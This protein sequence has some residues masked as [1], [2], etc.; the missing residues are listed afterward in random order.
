MI[1]EIDW[2]TKTAKYSKWLNKSWK[3][4]LRTAKAKLKQYKDTISDKRRMLEHEYKQ[5][6]KLNEKNP[7]KVPLTLS[8]SAAEINELKNIR[9]EWRKKIEVD[10]K[11]WQNWK[12]SNIAPRPNQ[13]LEQIK[14]WNRVDSHHIEYDSKLNTVLRDAAF[15]RIMDNKKDR[16]R[17]FLQG[18]ANN[19]L[20]DA[21][22]VF[23]QSNMGELSRIFDSYGMRDQ[24]HRCIQTR[25]WRYNASYQNYWNMDAETAYKTWWVVGL[26]NN[27]LIKTLPNA[28]PEHVS[29]FTNIAVTVGWIYAIY[30]IW[31]WFFGKNKEGNRNLLWKT[32][33]LASLYFVPQLLLWK[34]WYS[35]LW[36]ILSWK[37]DFSE[38][39]YRVSNSLWFLNGSSPE[40]YNQMAPGLLWMHIFPTGYTVAHVRA[41]QQTFSDQNVR[42]QRY[43]VTYARLNRDNTALANEF[44]NT[45]NANEY[46]EDEWKAFL[47]KL[48]IKDDARWDTVIFN[49]AAKTADKKTSFE[50][51][52]KSQWKE[53]KSEFKK[54]IDNYLKEDWEFNPANL[55]PD[56][57]KDNNEATYTMRE[58]DFTK[59]EKLDSKVDNLPI[60]NQKKSELK[61]AL[62]SF[63]DE[64][65]IANKP[66]PDDFDLKM[67]NGLLILKTNWWHESKIKLDTKEIEWF[68]PWIKF[69]DLAD[70]LNTADLANKILETQKWKIAKDKP[71]FQYKPERKWICFN[72]AT[73]LRQDLINRNNTWMD[74]RVLST[75]RWW[76]TSKIDTLYER[77]REFAKYL[78][79]RREEENK[80]EIDA[81][82]YPIVN[83]LSKTWITFTN[84][85]EVKE[86]ENWLQQVK[87]KKEASIW[88]IDWDSFKTSRKWFDKKLVFVNVNWEEDVFDGDIPEKFPTIILNKDKFLNFM[89]DKNNWMWWSKLKK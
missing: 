70:L 10:I 72:D 47:T 27:T 26:L 12:S 37:A 2:C 16:A 4:T 21:Q 28:K 45:F 66:D 38:L 83:A 79:D 53:K 32:A 56:W 62:E 41:L 40:V 17:E 76:A 65:T 75:G 23:Y 46:K 18:I 82:L 36:E 22:I 49:E 5:K 3:E 51:W 73:G 43:S 44:K 67:E 89:N 39:K 33:W 57:F 54:E 64:R 55:N 63:Y 8:I 69:T 78:S 14:Q 48:W 85:Q 68:G 50:L 19:S 77:P 31:K 29:N 20:S 61:T 52:M 88:K 24:V 42:K 7:D 11:E 13:S 25:G 71:P 74:T 6:R 60:D 58:V 86:L 9:F 30:R 84:E 81:T 87:K 80:V 15:L 59:K 1:F 34:D 35:L